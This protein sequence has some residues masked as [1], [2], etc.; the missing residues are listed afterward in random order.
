[1]VPEIIYIW[2]PWVMGM[3]CHA[4][5]VQQD[6]FT[7]GSRW[8]AAWTCSSSTSS[9]G[10]SPFTKKIPCSNYSY[11]ESGP[12]KCFGSKFGFEY[13]EWVRSK[14]I[15]FLTELEYDRKCLNVAYVELDSDNDITGKINLF[16]SLFYISSLHYFSIKNILKTGKFIKKI[17]N[18]FIHPLDTVF[19]QIFVQAK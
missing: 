2:Y 18:L 4:V 3:I 9:S 15:F 17:G 16:Y 8:W 1:M 12:E 11:F 13:T 19:R 5:P 7:L 14:R 10:T 6:Q